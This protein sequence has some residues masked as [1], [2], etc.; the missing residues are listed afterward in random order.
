M[1]A[2]DGQMLGLEGIQDAPVFRLVDEGDYVCTVEEAD[3][4]PDKSYVLLKLSVEHTLE[5][6][7]VNN[8]KMYLTFP[9][10][11]DDQGAQASKANRIK[12]WA[13]AAGLDPNAL[14]GIDVLTDPATWIGTQV[15][16]HVVVDVD[17]S[18]QW[19]DK[20]VIRRLNLV[21]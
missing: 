6:A 10:D 19:P 2:E 7:V 5:N 11:T 20:N 1:S 18:G 14:P 16:A 13:A 8:I 17:S 3:F 21:S 4:L 9:K 12:E 15:T